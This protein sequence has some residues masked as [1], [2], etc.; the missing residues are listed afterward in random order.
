VECGL[1]VTLPFIESESES[2]QRRPLPDI[3]PQFE[4]TLDLVDIVR[5]MTGMVYSSFQ[6][7]SPASLLID[8]VEIGPDRILVAAR[9]RAAAGGCPDCG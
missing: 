3:G 2:N 8:A 4:D 6:S 7:L 9:C 1:Q 5:G